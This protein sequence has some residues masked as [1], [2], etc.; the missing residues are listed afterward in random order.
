MIVRM[1]RRLALAA[2]GG[3]LVFAAPAYAGLTP[4]QALPI[5]NQWRTE[6]HLPTLAQFDSAENTGC[7]HHNHYMA[8]NGGLVH[9]EEDS[10]PYRTP[11]GDA[12]GNASVLA[13]PEG[14][15]RI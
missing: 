7:A 4:Q 12:A 9:D 13:Q 2:V 11:D 14:T 10:N 8:N 1:A 15:P 5:L 6:A 3:L